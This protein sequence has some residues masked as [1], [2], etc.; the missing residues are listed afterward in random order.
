MND[1]SLVFIA[2]ANHDELMPNQR[3]IAARSGLSQST[4][5][6][7]LRDSPL[8][9]LE[10]KE[11]VRAVAAELG[12]FPNPFVSSL[13][14]HI[15]AGREVSDQGC[16]A[17]LVAAKNKASWLCHPGYTKQYDAMVRQAAARGYRT[18]CFYLLAED[19]DHSG[20]RIDRILEARGIVGI[21]LPAPQ[22]HPDLKLRFRWERYAS[23]T[24]GYTWKV[25][26]VD[27]V[28][29]HHRHNIQRAFLTLQERGFQRIGLCLPQPAL[30]RVDGNWL[31]G[32]LHSQYWVPPDCR[33][34]I[35]I[36]H[37][38]HTP[39]KTFR[40]WL[41]RW[42]PDAL[43]SNN[44]FEWKW[45]EELNLERSV[46]MACLSRQVGS[47]LAGIDEVDEVVAEMV[48]DLVASKI[49]HNE[50][51]LP[52]HPKEILVEGIWFDGK[53]APKRKRRSS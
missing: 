43:I 27:R 3:A 25:P 52:A 51:G 35:F 32:Y 5:S 36:G 30:E 19:E 10:T 16:L 50:R 39:I 22:N 21:I 42:K 24:S 40:K 4:V 15:R 11:R 9:P 18:E 6:L 41:D 1:C 34:P 20:E 29:T 37:I 8:I 7:A 28:S 13:M 17:I 14:E 2:S 23:V 49:A 45:I 31:A 47:P 48:V 38:G 44:G 12:Y 26:D 33:L 53:T 46:A